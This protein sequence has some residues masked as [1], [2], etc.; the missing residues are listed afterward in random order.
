[1]TQTGQRKK[2]RSIRTRAQQ[3]DRFRSTVNHRTSSLSA[4]PFWLTETLSDP[5]SLSQEDARLYLPTAPRALRILHK[6][7][8]GSQY[9]TLL[10]R[11]LT[12]PTMKG[13]WKEID[14]RL[15]HLSPPTKGPHRNFARSRKEEAY[16]KL[17]DEI[18]SALTL[19]QQRLEPRSSI[20]KRFDQ[21]AL[22]A[23]E[24]AEAISSEQL[25]T[26]R[27]VQ[28]VRKASRRKVGI[29]HPAVSRSLDRLAFE[30]FPH[31]D[32]IQAFQSPQWPTLR[33]SERSHLARTFLR[34]WPS[35]S[36]LLRELAMRALHESHT[37]RNTPRLVDR[38]RQDSHVSVFIRHLYR[39][40]FQPLLDG[41][42]AGTL[43][44]IAS[45]VLQE[46]VTRE[47]V[48]KILRHLPRS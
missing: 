33:S 29:H 41:Q 44:H 7:T 6:R 42:M 19:C 35:M 38:T 40:F 30:F 3:A 37:I 32:A 36:N 46:D 22:D 16:H 10:G 34:P 45:L 1:M 47:T 18:L 5:F 25:A 2:A 9:H 23:I 4:P 43:A 27:E 14:A 17:W 31:S 24:L 48:V 26:P 8:P 13:A 28:D 20:A 11:L 39:A 15:A 12:A 21:L